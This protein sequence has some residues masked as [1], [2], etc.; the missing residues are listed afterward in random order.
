M[1]DIKL[2]KRK[3]RAKNNLMTK[4]L[5]LCFHKAP[6]IL[7]TMIDFLSGHMG[8]FY[9]IDRAIAI[10]GMIGSELDQAHSEI[11]SEEI[12]FHLL[13][14]F[15]QSPEKFAKLIRTLCKGNEKLFHITPR[16]FGLIFDLFMEK[17][18]YYTQN[19]TLDGNSNIKLRDLVTLNEFALT[20]ECIIDCIPEKWNR[21][22]F[23]LVVNSNIC[24]FVVGTCLEVVKDQ[25]LID[26]E[27]IVLEQKKTASVGHSQSESN[28]RIDF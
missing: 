6:Q 5:M 27:R 19:W 3:E 14:Y 22:A 21:Q 17:M 20:I 9:I 11:F 16:F 12:W 25:N 26:Y 18:K 10:I 15:N 1:E 7:I 13:S 28:V 8:S 4:K 23:D 24:D 2:Q